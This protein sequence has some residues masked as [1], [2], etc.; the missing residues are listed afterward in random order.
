MRIV[1]PDPNCVPDRTPSALQI[2]QNVDAIG[3]LGV[4]I[5]LITP[6]SRT[7]LTPKD[8]L[9][10][11]LP[12]N[13]CIDSIADLR[14]RWYFPSASNRP[15]YFLAGRRIRRERNCVLLVRNLRM[16]EYLL[17]AGVTHPLFFES[18]EIFAQTYREDHLH[19]DSAT[20]SKL[21]ALTAR[22]AFVYRNCRGLI[23]I[24]QNLA[25]DLRATY[26]V[27]TPVWVAPD[28]VDEKLAAQSPEYPPNATPVLLY[29]GSLH[30]WK[31]VELLIRA[32]QFVTGAMLRIVGGVANRVAE[33][34]SLA[35]Q[36]NVAG[37]VEFLGPIDPIKRFNVI[38][39][40]DICLLPSSNSSIGSRFTSP[41]KLFEYLAM[42]KPIVASDL[43]ALREVLQDNVTALLT[44]VGDERK[45][46][47]T[48]NL[49]LRDE[50]L[51]LRLGANAKEISHRYTWR[52][53][54][55]GMLGFIQQR[56]A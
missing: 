6:R 29:L 51:R 13:V 55:Q 36:L 46:A 47:A 27:D 17:K 22:E 14:R 32:M 26:Q 41:L 35:K 11:P 24:T 52:A 2:L 39:A 43:P 9:G 48:I 7:G 28:G 12:S 30:P 19:G 54:A 8:L 38:A 31:G 42:G 15:F 10:R 4:H 20:R 5:S 40:A 21:K 50:P 1:Y 33:L 3:Q 56:S 49:L 34:R 45:F 25:D 37:R 23:T 53:R 16:A 44:S 18:H